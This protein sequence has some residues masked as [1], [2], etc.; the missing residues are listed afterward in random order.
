MKM[1]KYIFLL[2]AVFAFFA[3]SEDTLETNPTNKASGPVVFETVENAYTALNGIYRAFYIADWSTSYD[4]E[5]PGIAGFSL[6][7]DLFGDD[8][9]QNEA[10]SAWFWYDY[11]YWVRGEIGNT[12]DRPYTFWY[13]NYKF[14]N[15][16]NYIIANIDN[17][18]G[19]DADRNSIKAQA[20][21]IRAYSY[22]NLIRY[23][24]RTYIGHESDPGVPLYTEPTNNNT[25][26]KGRGTVEDV[27]TQINQDLDDAITLFA[28]ASEQRHISHIDLYVTHGLK[29]RVALT[30]E[31]WLDAANHASLAR[32]K[33][34][35]SLMTNADVTDG[36]NPVSN[37]EWMWASEVND[38]QTLSW[39]SFWSHMDA[40][41]GGYAENSRK[42]VSRW[43]YD[44]IGPNDVRRNWFV[45]PA[46]SANNPTGPDFR[47]NQLKFQVAQSGS[48]ASDL[49]YM[50]MAEMYLIEAEARCMLTSYTDARN[51]LTELIG[52][53]DTDFAATLAAIPDGNTLSINTAGPVNNLLDFIILQRRIEL[54]GEGFRVFDIMRLKTGFDR[55]Y[56]GTNHPSMAQIII[57]DPE[58]WEWILMIPQKEFDGNVNMDP[59]TDQ[60]P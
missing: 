13:M 21:A 36:F 32:D 14:I 53:K 51:L 41:A 37:P 16:A 38:E 48:W 44:Q 35:L 27:Y 57:S 6:A 30:Q 20:L 3:C 40:A 28:T 42:C 5:N 34:G 2:L 12:S 29:A 54:W 26:G 19:D 22:F 7:S 24:Q 33:A 39:P 11:N 23:Y 43:L 60:N 25:E 47:Y 4:T 17:A 58:S 1:K 10:G 45:N 9:V 52:Y 18:T 15:N 59:A 55:A 49:L 50:R 46:T 8:M 31:N 56:A